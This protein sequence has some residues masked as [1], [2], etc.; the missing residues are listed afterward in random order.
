MLL[1]NVLRT[2][3]HLQYPG[4][5]LI[6]TPL[7]LIKPTPETIPSIHAVVILGAH[8]MHIYIILYNHIIPV[9]CSHQ[10]GSELIPKIK[11]LVFS[12]R[13]DLVLKKKPRNKS[14]AAS[15]FI[16]PGPNL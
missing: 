1:H 15:K 3:V 6:K 14:E 4:S 12:P 8:M 10:N 7:S 11:W 13:S 9:H 2:H 16:T 5:K